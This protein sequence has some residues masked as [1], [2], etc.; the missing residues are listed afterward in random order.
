MSLAADDLLDALATRPPS[1]E[2]SPAE[3]MT[4]HR[5]IDELCGAPAARPNR[6]R[7]WM[8]S[9]IAIGAASV[10]VVFGGTAAAFAA[11]APIPRPVR[12][13]VHTIGLPVDSPQLS[14][15][16]HA[17]ADLRD[18]LAG[19]DDKTLARA[20][21]QLLNRL[22]A[23][24]AG[25]R[26]GLAPETAP[27]LAQANERLRVHVT[28]P[29]AGSGS[30]RTRTP[31]SGDT[32][33]G[34]HGDNG[35]PTSGGSGSDHG[36]GQGGSTGGDQPS[37]PDNGGSGSGGAGDQPGNTSG[38]HDGSGDSGGSGSGS[39]QPTGGSDS[40]K[41]G[42]GSSGSGD[43][44]GGDASPRARTARGVDS[45]NKQISTIEG[46]EL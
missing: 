1:V 22:D 31:A 36:S 46:L 4:L 40:S 5:T 3:L 28:A 24:S 25:E 17:L 43:H 26:R 10:A 12:A 27:L 42:S 35:A 45:E 13:A 16:K 21:D 30:P 19:S 6:R 39:D 9:P 18:A 7:P 23:L 41:T 20:R 32:G 11:G 44:S 14:D 2:P 34:T 37:G 8:R 33:S 29:Q 38:G 15:A